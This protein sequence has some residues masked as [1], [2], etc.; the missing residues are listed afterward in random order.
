[1]LFGAGAFMVDSATLQRAVADS[2]R[3][4]GM[5]REVVVAEGPT[6]YRLAGC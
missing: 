5:F 1:M 2:M 4:T 6:D 3:S